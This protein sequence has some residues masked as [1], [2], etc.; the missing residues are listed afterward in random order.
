MKLFFIL[1]LVFP[2]L[3][4]GFYFPKHFI[5]PR[6]IQINSTRNN[7][8]NKNIKAGLKL[9]R[10]NNI[11]A[12]TFLC[13]SGGFI[14]DPHIFRLFQNNIFWISVLSTNL[15]M[16]AN[17]IIND[18]FDIDIDRI[19]NPSRPL[20]TGEISKKDAILSTLGLLVLAEILNM[21]FLSVNL[22]VIIHL[23][24]GFTFIYTPILKRILFVKNLSCATIVAFSL[25][26]AGLSTAKIPFS[27]HPNRDIL[28]IT[29]NTI[30]SGSLINEILLDMR[31]YTGDK[32]YNIS[33]VSTYFGKDVGYIT[34]NT[35]F[36][37]NLFINMVVLERVFNLKIGILYFLLFFPQLILLNK[38]R[39]RA[40]ENNKY[41]REAIQKYVSNTNKTL[42]CLLIYFCF[43]AS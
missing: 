20:I 5:R 12:T 36:Y 32:L 15:I 17:M 39:E 1:L 10:A 2:F 7:N 16:S 28:T 30:F 11:P 38:I 22:R 43:L 33:T 40:S 42:V 31:D 3:I 26:F 41:S 19:N 24:I 9:I 23:A 14:M 21:R 4:N 13:F 25:F 34:A 37:L 18:I 6:L 29:C 8:I 35:V 27:I